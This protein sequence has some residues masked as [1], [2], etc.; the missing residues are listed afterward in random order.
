MQK[1]YG[2]ESDNWIGQKIQVSVVEV[3]YG[4][5]YTK[6][7]ILSPVTTAKPKR[8]AYRPLT[9]EDFLY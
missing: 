3:L 2:K 1:W 6:K 7:I 8:D 4:D 9:E 5:Q